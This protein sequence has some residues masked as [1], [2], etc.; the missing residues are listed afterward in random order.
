M[1]DWTDYEKW[2]E[3][4]A[5]VVFTTESAGTPV[6]L[7]L[8]DDVCQLLASRIGIDHNDVTES[9]RRAVRTTIDHSGPL[10]SLFD[11]H[12]AYLARWRSSL[13]VSTGAVSPPPVL[14]F[15]AVT[16]LAAEAMGNGEHAGHA[17]FPH[18]CEALSATSE[19]DRQRVAES[20]RRVAE[21]MW[22]S[23]DVWLTRLNGRRGLPS[24]FA[25]SHRFVGLPMSQA[26]VRASDRRKLARMF[27]AFGLPPGYAMAP[28]DM[29]G[30]FDQW[31]KH[32]PCPVSMGLASLWAKPSARERIAEVVAN[33]LLTWDGSVP[34]AAGDG[35]NIPPRGLRLLANVTRGLGRSR[36]DLTVALRSAS[37]VPVTVTASTVE[38]TRAE[39]S[40]VPGPGGLLRL[41]H[42]QSLDL[43]SILSGVLTVTDPEGRDFSRHPRQIV[44]LSFDDAQAAYVEGERVQLAQEAILIVRDIG[45]RADDVEG[46]LE[47]VARPG[48][49]RHGPAT[50]GIPEGWALFTG[51]EILGRPAGAQASKYNELVPLASTQ[52][53]LAG[54]MKLPGRIIKWSSFEPPEIRAVSQK[55]ERIRVS[56]VGRESDEDDTPARSYMFDSLDAA[57]AVPIRDLDLPDG[58]Y[59]I[60]LFED[61]ARTPTQQ[62]EL[63][64]RSAETVDA[65][66][67]FGAKRLWHDF[68]GKGAWAIVSASQVDAEETPWGVDGPFSW[69]EADVETTGEV[70][71]EVWWTATKPV[72]AAERPPLAILAPDPKS[73]VITGAHY[74]RYPDWLGPDHRTSRFID[75]VCK[76]CGLVRRSPA[77]APRVRRQ[78]A[79]KAA[80]VSVNVGALAPVTAA[81]EAQSWAAALDGLMHLGGGKREWLERLGLQVDGTQLF[82][83]QFIKAVTSLG[84]IDTARDELMRFGDWELVPRYL[85]ELS[86]GSFALIGYW[87]R[88]ATDLAVSLAEDA[89][90]IGIDIDASPAI[91]VTSLAGLEHGQVEAIAS[92]VEATVVIEATD[93]MLAAL[94]PMSQLGESLPRVPVPGGRSQERFYIESASWGITNT[95]ER[96]GAYRVNSGYGWQYVFRSAGD[97]IAGTAALGDAY[98][99]K[100]LAAQQSGRPLMA[101]NTEKSLLF[102]PQ[103]ADLPGL[104]ERA[105]VLSSAQLPGR[106]TTKGDR[107]AKLMGYPEVLPQAAQRLWNLLSS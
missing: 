36:L 96:I 54:G 86:N 107:P 45:T 90:G 52:L 19:R 105:A 2:N 98:L 15:L 26:L 69:G 102:V 80:K 95:L 66:A 81:N 76:Y 78:Q 35:T 100:H 37:A 11:G 56:V 12:L 82:V 85:A 14:P 8:D 48:F 74:L 75:G 13:R 93:S 58:D 71:G 104:Y 32:Q 18:L 5:E 21:P 44:P 29:A 62:L 6:Y 31:V 53:T 28:G 47:E 94:L 97:L 25:L 70:G 20:Y 38:G 60:S 65:L 63:R 50:A 17:Y 40:F 46:I 34:Q 27:D 41:D 30:L 77:W 43:T 72:E 59:R 67:W 39:L 42:L 33:E 22:D 64:L 9:I 83:H 68:S 49:Q 1:I 61:G 101:Y 79:S 3:A 84:F 10:K 99:V 103:G 87:P 106:F 16:V 91:V 7:D 92:E 57:L 23:V 73:C 55:A 4:I 89:G 24:A 51:V 88:S